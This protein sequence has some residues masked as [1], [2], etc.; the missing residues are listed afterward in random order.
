VYALLG[1]A[2][3]A[4]GCVT[5][6][7]DRLETRVYAVKR[8]LFRLGHA[9]RS[10]QFACSIE[11]LVV[12]LAP[13]MGWGVPA[14]RGAERTRFVRAHRKSVQRW[15]DDL[16]AAGL[17][18]H[19]PERDQ[20]ARWWRTQIVLLSAP[21]PDAHELGVARE[22]AR[23]WLCRERRRRRHRHR[24]GHS[25]AAIRRRSVV[26]GRRSRTRLGR[27]R[28][29]GAREARRRAEVDRAIAAADAVRGHRGLLT[30][31]FGAPP[32]SASA[33]EDPSGTERAQTSRVGVQADARSAR[34][35]MVEH[36]SAA[37]T[38][39]HARAAGPS[40]VAVAPALQTECSGVP[41][42]VSSGRCTEDGVRASILEVGEC[43]SLERRGND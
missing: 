27:V 8:Y 14:R 29:V 6:G 22:R 16:Q 28:A 37:G 32:T 17:V 18:A 24:H 31:P 3:R 39:A 13:V 35:S 20:A 12:G 4:R 25:L 11:Q 30:H 19:E 43:R 26:P 2:R 23:G 34:T 21:A 33:L 15:L 40:A 38:G 36:S 5:P 10:A 7:D 42:V 1:R 9:A 41:P